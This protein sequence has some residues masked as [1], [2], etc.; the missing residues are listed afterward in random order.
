MKKSILSL[1]LCLL[2]AV[3]CFLPLTGASGGA[4]RV[5]TAE[6]KAGDTVQLNITLE[7]NPGF[8]NMMLLVGHD[9][10]LTLLGVEDKGVIPGQMHSTSYGENPYQLTWANDTAT[11][12]VTANGVIV[13][14]TF[15]V[16]EKAAPGLLPVTVSYDYENMDIVDVD[17]ESV[18]LGITN[19]GVTVAASSCTHKNARTEAGYPAGCETTGL[20]DGVYCP[21]CSVWIVPQ[22]EI[23]VLGHD[24]GAWTKLDDESHRR[25]CKR[26]ASHTETEPHVWNKGETENGA[27]TYTCGVCGAVRTE[28]VTPP[29]PVK[30]RLQVG[31]AAAERG[32]TVEVQVI[33]MGNPGFVNM[34][35]RVGYDAA[36]LRLKDVKDAGLI[37]GAMHTQE[38]RQ[39]PY[40]LTWSNDTAAA[41]FTET[42]VLATLTF[43]VLP[44]AVPGEKEIAL[45]YDLSGMEILNVD[46][47]AVDMEI[48]NGTVNVLDGECAHTNAYEVKGTDPTCLTAGLTAG[49]FCPDCGMWIIPQTPIAPQGHD[50]DEWRSVNRKTH[51]R[52]C[53][54]DPS[55]T[56]TA[57]HIWGDAVESD[58]MRT[59][60]CMVCGASK[61]EPLPP[62]G[63][64][65]SIEIDNVTAKAG[66]VVEVP[67]WIRH[68]DGFTSLNFTVAFAPE[69]T[70]VEVKDAGLIPGA[71]GY[72]DAPER[73]NWENSAA[74]RNFTDTGKLTTLVFKVDDNALLGEYAVE[75]EWKSNYVKDCEGRDLQIAAG[76]GGGITV[77]LSPGCVHEWGKWLLEEGATDMKEGVKA[78][79]C[80]KCGAKETS[81][82]SIQPPYAHIYPVDPSVNVELTRTTEDTVTVTFFVWQAKGLMS[83]DLIFFYDPD[84][85]TL[86]PSEDEFTGGYPGDVFLGEDSMDMILADLDAPDRIACS[87]F[88]MEMLDSSERLDLISYEFRLNDPDS[89][90]ETIAVYVAE[91][92]CGGWMEERKLSL[93]ESCEYTLRLNEFRVTCNRDDPAERKPGDIDLNGEI[94]S[95]DARLALRRAVQF[96]DRLSMEQLLNANVDGKISVTSADARL[97][98]RAAVELEDP[99]LWKQ[100]R[101]DP[102][103][104]SSAI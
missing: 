29:E 71:V 65:V 4:L 15:K 57:P 59:Y 99:E 8:V 24:Y 40:Q 38:L 61:T 50:W 84:R 36:S 101:T 35:L 39:N 7:N 77:E 20:T 17:L 89:A 48:V 102:N 10:A 1:T 2:L 62:E 78:R 19:G 31:S 86:V 23:G 30:G 16:S 85:M 43:E 69:L 18:R 64:Y 93:T 70:L 51:E 21:D 74:E 63:A 56:Q 41:N 82:A 67:L 11:R 100:R 91:A 53:L 73:L 88:F 27:T 75:L 45:S 92:S 55:H 98:L 79:Y 22:A 94:T 12:N 42:G 60:T 95:A 28:T 97:I 54:R 25:V 81:E 26:D 6:A 76:I 87:F 103:I 34:I 33:L 14:L 96:D 90:G 5:G 58:G 32:Q 44:D 68:N 3:S 13:S 9:P 80:T 37:P 104:R 47:Q 66:D 83:A 52:V 49:F 46:M 72:A